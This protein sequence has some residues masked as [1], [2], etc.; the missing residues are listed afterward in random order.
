MNLGRTSVKLWVVL[1]TLSATLLLLMACTP[2][3][4]QSTFDAAGPVAEKQLTLFYIVFWAAVF[5]FIVVGGILLYAVIRFRRKPGEDK[6]PVQVHGNTKLEIGWTIA[7]AI[8]LAVIAVPTVV[9]IFDIS[10]P[11]LDG[12][13]EVNVI[14]HQWWW[15]FEYPE[16]NVITANE[17]HVPVDTPVILNLMSDDVIHS[18][19]I[20]KLA[21]KVDVIPSNLNKMWFEASRGDIESL[22]AVFFGQCAEFCGDAHAH[23]KFKVIVD[24]EYAFND[25]VENYHAI[26]ARGS[27]TE[28]D[29]LEGAQLFASKG[30]TLCHSA[31]GPWPKAVRDGLM[32][33]FV[34][35]AAAFP[36]PNLTNLGTRNTLAA[37]VIEDL[38]RDT[39]KE[40]LTDP[41]EV[42]PGNHMADLANVYN[43]DNQDEML[44]ED[45]IDKLASYLLSL[46]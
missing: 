6:M 31:T 40:W 44:T 1:L 27:P 5:V 28:G 34:G 41:D 43:V 37:G 10:D 14:G 18:F 24:E 12:A 8:V 22:P 11:P 17:M 19:W 38:N 26:T 29:A 7:P 16:Q 46:K 13:L 20:P 36:G 39:L 3:H 45:D 42:K 4:P 30:C 15:E 33:A 9:Y 25:W 35:G 23:M 2:S 32:R 21:G